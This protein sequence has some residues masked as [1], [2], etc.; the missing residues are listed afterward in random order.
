MLPMLPRPLMIPAAWL[1]PR[2]SSAP[3]MTIFDDMLDFVAGNS[4]ILQRSIIECFQDRSHASVP[5]CACNACAESDKN[6]YRGR[7]SGARLHNF[8]TG[9]IRK[10]R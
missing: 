9:D 7:R 4:E 10:L 1:A 6:R 8:Q 5:A 3:R 2:I